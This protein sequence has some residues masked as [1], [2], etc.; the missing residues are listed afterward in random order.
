MAASYLNRES[1]RESLITVTRVSLSPDRRRATVFVTVLPES[2]EEK[3]LGFL[4]RKESDFKYHV[5]KKSELR[6]I[7]KISFEIDKG[8]K[9]RQRLDELS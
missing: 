4:S 3:A 7:P 9:S 5:L 6:I 2:V 1:N 8:E